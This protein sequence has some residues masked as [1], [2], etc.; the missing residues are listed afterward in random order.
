MRDM[1]QQDLRLVD[2]MARVGRRLPR[3][4]V[5]KIH[6]RQ[7]PLNVSQDL[8][9]VDLVILP[10]LEENTIELKP[11]NLLSRDFVKVL[12]PREGAAP[13]PVTLRPPLFY[14]N[15]EVVVAVSQVVQVIPVDM[16]GENSQ[17]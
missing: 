10:G 7:G 9:L 13:A 5:L 2:W 1:N 8:M 3:W 17:S 16:P 12:R 14:R 15:I 6:A 11:R 4:V